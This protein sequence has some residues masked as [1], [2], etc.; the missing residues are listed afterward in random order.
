MVVTIKYCV[1]QLRISN[2]WDDIYNFVY[3]DKLESYEE[4]LILMMKI[5]DI[6]SNI[7]HKNRLNFYNLGTRLVNYH[8]DAFHVSSIRDCLG[9]RS[10][11]NM[12]LLL[13][14][15]LTFD[16][17]KTS[18]LMINS[19]YIPA[20]FTTI[21]ELYVYLRSRMNYELETCVEFI[22]Y[23]NP[24][25]LNCTVTGEMEY[26]LKKLKRLLQTA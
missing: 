9:L 25:Y 6:V 7:R 3:I 17:L 8:S 18:K 5:H 23:I 16:Q 13:S 14:S 2:S 19:F 24:P 11:A 12:C 20:M 10:L 4:Y 21:E 15:F 1:N 22:K 26:A